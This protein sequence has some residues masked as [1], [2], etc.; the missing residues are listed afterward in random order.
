MFCSRPNAENDRI[1]RVVLE[2]QNEG[3]V[4]GDDEK[5][6]KNSWDQEV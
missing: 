6:D 5:L 4:D 2:D 1:G 3:K